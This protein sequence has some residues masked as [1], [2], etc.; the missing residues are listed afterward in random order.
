MSYSKSTGASVVM[1]KFKFA[2]GITQRRTVTVR[3][4]NLHDAVYK[5]KDELDRRC[6]NKNQ[7]P[8]VGWDLTLLTSHTEIKS[9]LP[10][11]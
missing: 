2:V 9:E 11:K 5:A 1:M 7:E 10:K 4:N 3:A 8:P 6:A